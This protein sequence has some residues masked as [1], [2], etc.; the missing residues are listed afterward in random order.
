MADPH[1][2]VE[3]FPCTAVY[4]DGRKVSLYCSLQ[5][6][7]KGFFV[8]QSTG[9]VERIP[10]T[11]VYREGRKVDLIQGWRG[12]GVLELSEC[13]QVRK[14]TSSG[15]PGDNPDHRAEPVRE[16]LNRRSPLEDSVWSFIL[17]VLEILQDLHGF[18]FQFAQE[19]RKT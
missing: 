4:R 16:K 18:H 10:C 9:M 8:L 5:G 14:I 3:R 7:Q 17:E 19:Q 11:A 15:I 2:A 1:P 13:L 6:W 12:P